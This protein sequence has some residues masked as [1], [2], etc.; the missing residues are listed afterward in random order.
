[1]HQ[2]KAEKPVSPNLSSKREE[3]IDNLEREKESAR[4]RERKRERECVYACMCMDMCVCACIL[5]YGEREGE[6]ERIR[7]QNFII[8]PP[9]CVQWEHVQTL[10]KT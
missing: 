9:A 10:K 3:K 1:M 8:R 4:E 2:D 6:R 5:T 7:I